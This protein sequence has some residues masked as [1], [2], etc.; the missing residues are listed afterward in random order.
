MTDAT[1]FGTNN[2]TM[3]DYFVDKLGKTPI[4]VPNCPS[5]IFFA[6]PKGKP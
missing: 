1:F 5:L 2:K 6:E 3:H 4:D